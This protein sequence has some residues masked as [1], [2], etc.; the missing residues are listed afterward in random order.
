MPV[1]DRRRRWRLTAA[2]RP[3]RAAQRRGR[4]LTASSAPADPKHRRLSSSRHLAGGTPHRR[5]SGV[6]RV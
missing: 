2:H 4:T 6:L 3:H 5:L 1:E